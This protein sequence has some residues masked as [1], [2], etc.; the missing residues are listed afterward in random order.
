ASPRG[1]PIAGGGRPPNC[2]TA[3]HAPLSSAP[4]TPSHGGG[5]EGSAY[6]WA[7]LQHPTNR[8]CPGRG[9]ALRR[10]AV[11]KPGLCVSLLP[12]D[13]TSCHSLYRHLSRVNPG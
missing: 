8:W 4:L 6:R 5:V 11:G 7:G 1:S 12:P 9:G 2:V 10:V 13:L 3:R